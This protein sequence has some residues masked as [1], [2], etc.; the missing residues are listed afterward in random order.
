MNYLIDRVVKVSA[1]IDIINFLKKASLKERL[2]AKTLHEYIR[3][4]AYK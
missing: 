4:Q 1:Y 2:S 3:R